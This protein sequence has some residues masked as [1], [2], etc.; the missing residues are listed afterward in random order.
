MVPSDEI[1]RE[2]LSLVIPKRKRRRTRNIT[3]NY[4]RSRANDQKWML[5]RKPGSRQK[6]KMLA[7]AISTGVWQILSNHTYI[8]GDQCYLQAEGGPIGLEL[9]GAVSR[10][11]MMMW[12]KSY[13]KMLKQAGLFMRL[14]ERYVDD[15]N[16][17][18]E[19][20]PAGSKY[21]RERKKIIYDETELALRV[22]EEEEDRLTRILLDI[23]N[24]R[25]RTQ[26][27]C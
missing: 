9:T 18:A 26:P 25:G 16:Q 21:D 2:G 11:F 17:V 14:Y 3:I 20:P 12:D 13:L 7:L 27:E 15:S 23:A 5:A 22:D 10:P 4:L 8:V 24:G 6:K 1:E 19:V